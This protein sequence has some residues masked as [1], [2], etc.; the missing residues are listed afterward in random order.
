MPTTIE[1]WLLLAL[2]LAGYEA[3]IF[4]VFVTGVVLGAICERR[5]WSSYLE[6][7]ERSQGGPEGG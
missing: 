6:A 1:G 5:W 4:V 3:M 2:L 7:L